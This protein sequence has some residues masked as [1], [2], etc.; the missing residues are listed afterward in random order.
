MKIVGASALAN[1]TS[2]RLLGLP[3]GQAE[4]QAEQGRIAFYPTSSKRTV[5]AE[6]IVPSACAARRVLLGEQDK[7]LIGPLLT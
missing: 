2:A 4:I 3:I 5:G 6:T 7:D 1:A